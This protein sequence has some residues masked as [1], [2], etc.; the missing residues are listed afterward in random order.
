MH[1]L[2]VVTSHTPFSL[3]VITIHAVAASLVIL[4]GPVNMVRKSKDVKHKA[5]GRSWVVAMYATCVS[6]MFIYTL[7]GGFTIF[8]ALAILTF[9]TTTLGVIHIRRHR[10]RPHVA[11]MVGSYVGA[12]I[13]GGFAVFVP[14]RFIPVLAIQNP[15]VLWSVAAAV[16]V[17]ATAWVL[18]VLTLFRPRV[19]LSRGHA[20]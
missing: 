18:Y 17:L 10:V 11:N 2:A 4:I 12:L 8:H 20:T 13:A 9:T 6:G 14:G 15:V 3:T 7:S 19:S 1:T 16:V 5:L